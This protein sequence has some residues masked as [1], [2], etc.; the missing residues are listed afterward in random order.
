MPLTPR[1]LP[2]RPNVTRRIGHRLPA[3]GGALQRLWHYHV[4]SIVLVALFVFTFAGQIVAG[5]LTFNDEQ[6]EHGFATV[7]LVGYLVTGHFGEATFENW[8]SEFLQMG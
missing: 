6:L 2:L 4:L 7:S 8:E 5:W 3:S 1:P